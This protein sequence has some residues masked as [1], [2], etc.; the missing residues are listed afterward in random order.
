MESTDIRKEKQLSLFADGM[1]LHVESPK[2]STHT[3]I[4]NL[5][6]NLSKVMGYKNQQKSVAFLYTKND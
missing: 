6:N 4:L 1:T 5:I 2:D 3:N